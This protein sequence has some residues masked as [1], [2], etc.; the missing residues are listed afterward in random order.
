MPQAETGKQETSNPFG[1]PRSSTGSRLGVLLDSLGYWRWASIPEEPPEGRTSAE[2]SAE[3]ITEPA[4]KLPAE[5][6]SDSLGRPV[7]VSIEPAGS[8]LG[9]ATLHVLERGAATCLLAKYQRSK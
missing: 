5:E 1:Y 6:L 4:R 8:L 3:G 7:G 2:L 9:G